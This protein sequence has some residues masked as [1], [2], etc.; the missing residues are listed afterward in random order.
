MFMSSTFH[1]MLTHKSYQ[2]QLNLLA[3]EDQRR[4]L[5][6]IHFLMQEINTQ[7]EEAIMSV[8]K[9]RDLEQEEESGQAAQVDQEE[10]ENR[11]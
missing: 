4:F 11:D 9:M 10:Q 7:F 5:K 2:T 6:F 1:Y 3:L 8:R